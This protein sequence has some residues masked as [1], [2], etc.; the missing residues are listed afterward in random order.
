MKYQ[1]SLDG[2][3]AVATLLV[4]LFHAKVPGMSAGFVGVDIFFVLSGFLIT[5][6]LIAEHERTGA[7]D[8]MDFTARR[9]RRLY[10][11]MILFL[12]VYLAVAPFAWPDIPTERHQWDAF[13]AGFYMGDYAIATGRPTAVIGHLWSLGVEEKFYLLWPFTVAMALRLRRSHA[14]LL[15]AAMF[16]GITLWRAYNVET[17]DR[18]WHVYFR[19]DT[20]CSGLL[21]GALAAFTSIRPRAAFGW[22][23]LVGLLVVLVVFEWRTK[24]S[25]A[26][27]ISLAEVFSLMVVMAS[28]SFLGRG[29]LPWLGKMSYGIYLWHYLFI[30][31]GREHGLNWAENLIFAG[32]G[33]IAC[34]ALSYYAVEQWL[35]APRR[36]PT[37]STT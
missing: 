2:L 31:F 8:Y 32:V 22:I 24:A 3:R 29:V 20:H 6:L 23:G 11:A 4:L 12:L 17:L 21:L 35:K 9:L 13:I 26:I 5:R 37:S 15:I 1:P 28:P 30:K 25:A 14:Q 27:G 10:P 7:I 33:G 18:Y 16:V 36:T 19:F 34:A